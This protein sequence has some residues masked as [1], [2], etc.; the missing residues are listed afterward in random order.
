MTDPKTSLDITT[1]RTAYESGTLRARQLAEMILARIEAGADKA[2]WIS[3]R[4]R[5]DLLTEA[6]D[7]DRQGPKGRPLFGIPFAIKDNI[8][9]AGMTTTAACPEFAYVAER[10]A[11]AVHRLRA[12]GALLVGKTNLDQF[13]TGLVGVRSPYGAPRSVFDSRYISGGSSSGSA[14]AVASSLV[15]FALGTDTAGS[16][17][18]PAAFNNLVGLKPSRGLLSAA[19]VVPACRSLDCPS[20]FALT[21]GDAAKVLAI[22]GGFDPL[23][24]YSRDSLPV[25]PGALTPSVSRFRFAV[26]RGDQLEF[27]DGGNWRKLFAQTVERLTALGGEA[28]EID[29][30][31]FAET[32]R[33]LYDGPWVAERY[34]AIGAFLDAHPQAGHPTVRRIVEG[35]RAI[36]AHAAF[37]AM[38]RLE[39]LRRACGEIWR[40]ADILLTPTA[41]GTFTVD[42]VEA[43]PVALNSKLGLYTNFM[44][45]LDLAGIAVPAG[46][47]ADGLP[48]GVTLAA[49]A[50]RDTELLAIGDALHRA[51]ALPMGATAHPL[52][53]GEKPAANRPGYV[54]CAM[55]G[56]HMAGLPLNH[57]VTS[58]RGRLLGEALTA[59][60][61]RLYLLD[62]MEPHRPGL[63][64]QSS[65]GSAI[66]VELWE[67]PETAFGGFVNAIPSPLS[68]GHIQLADGRSVMGFL[69]EAAA[70]IQAPDISRHGGW[71]GWLAA[72]RPT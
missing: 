38:Y 5:Q 18:V 59:P 48:F 44:N 67:M 33:L 40:Q 61:Y 46:F 62:D 19:G 22:A 3:L 10:T 20:I 66:S 1:L 32:A 7:L 17:R 11:T 43:D 56:A 37:Q 57:H 54:L 24:A 39:G 71:R 27:F 47:G 42:A 9:V 45:L 63:V 31:P 60:L 26:P 51:A 29:F 69:C 34:A 50:G 36:P 30:T 23:D 53:N 13:A 2:V 25:P 35:G 15:S 6:E 72:G 21:A 28:V 58:R 4:N 70:V 52:P 41:G 12:A 14:V 68:I 64:R 16:G 49:P 55:V 8:D 65:E